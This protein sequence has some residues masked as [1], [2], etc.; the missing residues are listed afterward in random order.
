MV[1]NTSPR[2][3]WILSSDNVVAKLRFD[4]QSEQFIF[5]LIWN[6]SGFYVIDRISNDTKMNSDY[7][8]TNILIP[9][10]LLEQAIFLRGRAPHQKRVVIHLD[11]CSVHTSRASTDWLEEH[12]I[13]HMLHP[14]Y[15]PDLTPC[16]FYWFP[17]SKE[18][19]ERIQVADEHQFLSF[20][21]RF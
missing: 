19:F 21:K 8:M 14:P 20:S 4:I 13:C 12:E 15:S 10:I 17:P 3:V 11:N 2:L 1:F 16:D 9:L 18:K 6:P 5:S 7:F